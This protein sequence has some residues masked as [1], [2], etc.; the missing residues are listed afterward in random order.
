VKIGFV[1]NPIAGMGGA[2]GLKGTDGEDVLR[3]ARARGAR[4]VSAARAKEALVAIQKKRLSFDFIT[5]S[6]E[7][8]MD[9]LAEIGI[10]SEIVL[11]AGQITS[12]ADTI[13]A[14][15]RFVSRGADIILFAGGDGTARDVVQVVDA[16]VPIIGIPTGVKMNSAVFAHRLEDVADLL[17]SFASARTTR[18]AE[19]MDV[20]EESYR[21]GLLKARLYAF[22]KV[23]DDRTHLQSGKAVYHSGTADDEAEELGLYVAESMEGGTAYIIGP[24][25]T[26]EAVTRHLGETKT[27]LG[28]DVV[29]DGKI[30]LRDVTENSLLDLLSQGKR[31][32]IIVTPIGSQGFV[33]G[34]GNQQISDKV[35]KKVGCQNV[36]V[37]ATP[38]KLAGTPVLRVD[39]GDAE[40]DQTLRGRVK[41][42]TGYKR[43][44][45]MPVQ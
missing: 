17:E 30:I 27:I 3:E 11:K 2:V 35:I 15:T 10:T 22:A 44:K 16:K 12:S 42:L 4:K 28:V 6:G 45:L 5:C 25:S 41:V 1:V 40:L 20:D 26:T 31:A 21:K 38:T 7:M 37:I 8:G 33:F 9:E 19:I 13:E 34:R 14:V 36:W 23:P 18:D 32:V 24:G 43:K 29:L 39:S